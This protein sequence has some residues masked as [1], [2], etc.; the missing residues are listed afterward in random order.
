[1]KEQNNTTDQTQ[2]SDSAGQ[3]R[4]PETGKSKRSDKKYSILGIITTFILVIIV[5]MLGERL[6][7]DANR[8]L[9]P[10]V[11]QDYTKWKNNERQQGRGF[12]YESPELFSPSSGMEM[13]VDIS[14]GPVSSTKVY[15]PKSEEGRYLMYELII[16]AIIIIPLFVL[17]FA[18]FYFKKE[19]NSW[20]P[21]VIGFVL[22]GFW[23]MLHLLGETM[24]FVMD[25][26]KNIAIYVILVILAVLFGGLTFYAQS[27][28]AEKK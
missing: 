25:A 12:S 1:M 22:A 19:D 2:F 3:A 4:Q 6:I 17:A 21:I 5:I 15:Y 14:S 11:E 9:N 10:V 20:R 13:A 24:T 27:K 23:L 8:I 28:Y 7:F 26:Y 16:H 18:L